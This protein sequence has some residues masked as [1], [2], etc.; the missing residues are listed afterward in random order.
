MGLITTCW[1]TWHMCWAPA[2]LWSHGYKNM[3][4]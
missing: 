2:E 4:S 3:C 1:T